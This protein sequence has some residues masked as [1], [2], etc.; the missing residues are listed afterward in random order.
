V[1]A[2]PGR[3]LLIAHGAPAGG[4]SVRDGTTGRLLEQW[5]PPGLPGRHETFPGDVR[6]S[7]CGRFVA[8]VDGFALVTR[9]VSGGPPREVSH[10]PAHRPCADFFESSDGRAQLAY[11]RGGEIWFAD[12]ERGE[13][14][15]ASG[16]PDGKSVPTCL[17]ADAGMIAAGYVETGAGGIVVVVEARA[18]ATPRTIAIEDGA[19]C[20]AVAP[21]FERVVVATDAGAVLIYD[22]GGERR[23]EAGGHT[24]AEHVERMRRPP[25]QRLR[26]ADGGKTLFSLQSDRIA[27][28]DLPRALLRAELHLLDDPHGYLWTTPPTRH[29]P[30]GLVWT[31][32]P[33]LVSVTEPREGM[34]PVPLADGDP[35]RGEYLASLSRPEQ[36]RARARSLD[37]Y[38]ELS[39]RG[40]ERKAARRAGRMLRL[41]S[42]PGARGDPKGG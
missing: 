25:N 9:S 1:R 28:Y 10:L 42:G 13:G 35:R 19:W 37:D 11:T 8:W 18:D 3:R 32:R 5:V 34:L 16:A 14:R 4:M 41:L 24:D 15:R 39:V 23:L 22:F 36:V 21:E 40:L 38:E 20:V 26:L 12:A 2:L 29:H 27:I 30:D 6:V 31:N 17:H 33:D 7:Q